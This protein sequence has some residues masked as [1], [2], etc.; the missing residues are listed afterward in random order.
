MKKDLGSREVFS[1]AAGAMISSGL[2]VLPGVL[3]EMTGPSAWIAYLV[4]AVLVGPAVVGKAELGT[5]M[6]KAGGTYY[7]VDRA[8]GP[9]MGTLGGFAAWF[10]LSLKTAF[11]L[12][13]VGAF[14]LLLQPLADDR[15]VKGI[16]IAVTIGATLLNMVGVKSAARVQNAMVL[17]LLVILTGFVLV[18]LPHVEPDHLRQPLP[19]GLGGLALATGTAFVSFGGVTKAAA[20]AE[21]MA[22]PGKVLPRAMFLA[23]GVVTLLYVL[24]VAVT[25]GVLGPAMGGDLNPVAHA[26]QQAVGTPGL[27]I[28]S[29]AALTA[30][31]TTGNAGVMAA[32]RMPM[33]M[34]R[35]DLLPRRLARVHPRLG[36]PTWAVAFTGMLMVGAIA[37]LDLETLVKTASVMM[38]LLFLAVN[39]AV[40][41]MRESKVEFYRPTIRVPLYP[42]TPIVGIVAY[43]ALSFKLGLQPML[44]AGG[45]LLAGFVWYLLYA[46]VRVQRESAM[47]H[48]V[49]QVANEADD[50]I[51]GLEAELR[52]VLRDRDGLE[53]DEFD[54]LVHDALVEDHD[55]LSL[56]CLAAV[57][58]DAVGPAVGMD[59]AEVRDFILRREHKASSILVPG[60][61]A[62][63][64]KAPG[65][66]RSQMLL[67]RCREGIDWPGEH[68]PVHAIAV[69]A[70]SKDRRH[71][72]LRVL[73]C[74][75]QIAYDPDFGPRWMRVRD[76]ASLVEL[77][78]M[79]KRHRDQVC[80]R[81][82]TP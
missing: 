14:F 44:L 36:T 34:S 29:A 12:F 15:T 71:Q 54:E 45:F 21:E 30:Y 61:A 52:G 42:L 23:F 80:S 74:L 33:A 79:G 56:P 25:I 9:A 8:L 38:I 50:D 67:L 3:Y 55:Q 4:A 62:I 66:G 46:R 58:G 18:A 16:A 24:V 31:L 7:F 35:D 72:R 26:A 11:A 51:V 75:A 70:T 63:L 57:V 17:A 64:L 2:F 20:L 37:F 76:R 53:A 10:S 47:L 41:V 13:G 59:T 82:P 5:A 65:E 28:L 68:D 40:I 77:L 43:A 78:S 1:I 81:F 22:D 48:I 49:G 19:H 60:M 27:V 73:T 6:P 32:S 39:V 69:L